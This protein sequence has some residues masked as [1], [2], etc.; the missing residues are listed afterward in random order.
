[1]KNDLQI[2]QDVMNQLKWDPYI[3]TSEIDVSVKNG[4]VKLSGV[5]DS[6]AKKIA[7]E[8]AACKVRGV[9]A[10]AEE[11]RINVSP[12]SAKTDAELA[13]IVL[14]TLRMH[15][16]VPEEN[17]RV[18]VES[19][20]V[21]LDGEVEWDYQRTAARHAI[22]N[23]TGIKNVI[24]N[25]TVKPKVLDRDIK[26][27]IKAAFHRTATIDANKISVDIDGSKVTL[28]GKVRS[29]TEKEDAESAA[30][31]APG[32]ISVTSYLEVVPAEEYII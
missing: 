12:A 28:R 8:K 2:L 6:Y 5:V 4:I 7:A 32:V 11:I 22:S 24:S 17:I 14:N 10:I 26:S 29:Y 30:W 21:T 23:L 27:K 25:L 20:V 3:K 31:A 18:K 16:T 9:R 1:M 19:G 15:T 13:E